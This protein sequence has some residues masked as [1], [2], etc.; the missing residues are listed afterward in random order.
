MV[1]DSA[2]AKRQWD[3]RPTVRVEQILEDIAQ[4]AEAHPEWLGISGCV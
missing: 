2:K 1:L 3:W 4:H